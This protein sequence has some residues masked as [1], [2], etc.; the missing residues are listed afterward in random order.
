[1][2]RTA[3]FVAILLLN[4]IVALF[5]TAIV[6]SPLAHLFRLHSI[7]QIIFRSYLLDAGAAFVLGYI[8]YRSWQP[9][10]AKWVWI[11]GTCWLAYKLALM[12][13]YGQYS[14]WTAFSG[15]DCNNGLIAT[16]CENWMRFT[17]PALHLSAYSFG[18]VLCARLGQTG[19]PWFVNALLGRFRPLNHGSTKGTRKV[20]S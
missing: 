6:Q 15:V 1:M 13:A 14:I 3:R 12:L 18:S 17:I 20:E 19:T 5:G 2:I 7:N 16:G 10:A 8:V 4:V 11:V 9:L